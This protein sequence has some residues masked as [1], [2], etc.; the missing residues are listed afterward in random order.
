MLIDP[1]ADPHE[2]K[3]LANDPAHAAVVAELSGLVGK[4]AK[5]YAAPAK[6]AK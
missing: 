5:G 4:Y 2:L 6:P 3:N 1:A